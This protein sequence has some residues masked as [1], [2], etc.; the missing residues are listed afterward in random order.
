MSVLLINP[1][2]PGSAAAK[3]YVPPLG[4]A[5]VGAALKERGIKA[6]VL[7]ADAMEMTP[8]E[9]ALAVSKEAPAVVGV[10]GLTPTINDCYRL[11][12]AVRPVSPFLAL[13][14]P[15]ASALGPKVMS[16]APV[17]LDAVVCGEA[18]ESFPRLVSA[19]LDGKEPEPGIP[20]V[21]YGAGACENAEWPRVSDL[22]ALPFPDRDSLPEERYRHPFSG[23][24]FTTMITSRGCPYRC[25]FCDKHVSGS[26]WR[27][28]SPENV[29]SEMRHVLNRGVG[30]IIIYDDLFTLDRER[31]IEICKGIVSEGL[32]LKW[33]CEGRV[34]RVD[35]ECLSWMKKAGCEM[36][37]YGVESASSKGLRFLQKDISIDEVRE[38]FALTREAGIQTLGYFILGIPG[39]TME[40]EMETVRLAIELDAD[41]A[42]FGTLSPF[43]GTPLYDYASSQ[44]WVQESRSVGPAER[45]ECRPFISDGYWTPE[46]LEHIMKKA[47]QRFYFRPSYVLKRLKRISSL[48]ELRTGAL[49]A[50]RLA[51]WRVRS[52]K[53]GKR[54]RGTRKKH[55]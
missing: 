5:Y 41:Y 20:G 39:E 38:A 52:L 27:P 13:G 14:G 44:G 42:Q 45:G 11:L 48:R 21:L 24:P 23:G 32:E 3:L 51:A 33:K 16:E 46:R 34:N 26:R 12:E 18:E 54:Y 15:H 31:V 6:K 37:A 9:V 50:G 22:D 30:R 40:D 1:P 55:G 28:R 17:G 53:G 43:P 49:Q 25:I 7:D 2:S 4:L 47:H 10:T 36:I 19:L 35:R 29:I 8:S